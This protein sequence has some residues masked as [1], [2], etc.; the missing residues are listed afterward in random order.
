M[1]NI[2]TSSTFILNYTLRKT[3]HHNLLFLEGVSLKE[4]MWKITDFL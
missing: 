4:I 3:S 2:L 1:G